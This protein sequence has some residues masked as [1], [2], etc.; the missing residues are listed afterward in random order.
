MKKKKPKKES[1]ASRLRREFK[2][3]QE[4]IR[5]EKKKAAGAAGK[6][7]KRKPLTKEQ[8]EIHASRQRSYKLRKELR[9]N[10][11]LDKAG[12]EKLYN[13][14][15]NENSKQQ[16]ARNRTGIKERKSSLQLKALK[17]I[18]KSTGILTQYDFR[19]TKDARKNILAYVSAGAKTV[20][21]VSTQT[22]LVNA[23]S[24]LDNLLL[25]MDAYKTVEIA[26]NPKTGEIDVAITSE[27]EEEE[28][29]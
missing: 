9:E 13:K 27:E 6:P 26:Y 16:S 1:E 28:T 15:L 5:K 11:S 17:R 12:R 18:K 7:K 2:K 29:E 4:S 8:K 21:G 25:G 10:E 3:D 19:N 23:L 22:D 20:N 24:Q 14:I